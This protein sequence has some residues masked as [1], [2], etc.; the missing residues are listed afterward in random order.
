MQIATNHLFA[1]LDI[2]YYLDGNLPDERE[3]KEFLPLDFLERT[4][5]RP[6]FV[7]GENNKGYEIEFL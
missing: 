7:I 5:I 6:K 3:N 2:V 1:Y 4:P